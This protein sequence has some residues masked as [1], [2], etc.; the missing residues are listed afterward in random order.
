MKISRLLRLSGFWQ[1]HFRFGSRSLGWLHPQSGGIY[2]KPIGVGAAQAQLVRSL[3]IV[4]HNFI[5]C[6]H[7][8]W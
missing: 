6:K 1:S 4:S 2:F 3:W 8:V 7:A 5:P